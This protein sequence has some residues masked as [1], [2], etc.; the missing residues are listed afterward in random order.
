MVLEAVSVAHSAVGSEARILEG[1]C[2]AAAQSG[3]FRGLQ[4]A[5]RK[6]TSPTATTYA[7]THHGNLRQAEEQLAPRAPSNSAAAHPAS[8]RS[9]GAPSA[10]AAR[11]GAGRPIATRAHQEFEVDAR[12]VLGPAE[13]CPPKIAPHVT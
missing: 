3:A 8:P 9:A 2:S 5:A 11:T 1:L 7:L 6:K 10:T 13:L 12:S 4:P